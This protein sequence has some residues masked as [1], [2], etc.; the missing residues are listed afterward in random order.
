MENMRYTKHLVFLVV[1]LAVAFISLSS[2]SAFASITG[3]EVNGVDALTNGRD[4]AVF[5][6]EVLPIRVFFDGTDY[7]ED[8]RVKVWI[9]GNRDYTF[10]SQRFDVLPNG[11][12]SKLV[13]VQ[14]PSDIDPSEPLMLEVS[15]ESRNGG[16]ADTVEIDLAAQRESYLVQA[17]DV[18]MPTQVT[19]GE[20]LSAD[21]VLKNR[22]RQFAED[23]FVTVRIPAL[24][25]SNR[26]Y[27]GD[28]SD[29]DQPLR[30][31]SDDRLDK[32]D[33]AQR[34]VTLN[35]PA[36][37]PS[38]VYNV[39]FEVY[40]AD[41]GET[42]TK[43]IAIVGASENSMV[44]LSST[45]KTFAVGET[46]SYT[47]TLV[48]TGNKVRVYELEV[49]PSTGLKANVDESVVAVP[50]G[51]SKTVK[52]DVTAT[53]AGKKTITVNVNSNGELVESKSLIANVEG[54]SGITGTNA[55]VVLTVVLAIIFVVLLVVLIVLLTR[56]PEKKEEFGE[57]YY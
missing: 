55:T 54:R 37:A 25:V 21:V 9:S 16:V 45:S 53:E 49:I 30:D 22:G 29:I 38:G 43:R 48:N 46:A 34:R 44:V 35:I 17:L 28:L 32:E 10:S 51:S 13:S 5:A 31:G 20:M 57:S 42:V 47:I 50:A 8:A 3:V 40:N 15:V 26:V 19:A 36:N 41:Y 39:E 4:V 33:A 23:T 2:V 56:K 27:F 6:G 7:S 14:V 24:G 18:N 12:Y 1:A 52:V 11:T